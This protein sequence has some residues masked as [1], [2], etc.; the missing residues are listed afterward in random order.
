LFEARLLLESELSHLAAKRRT[1]E[2][3]AILHGILKQSEIALDVREEFAKLHFEFHRE[4]ARIA[5]NALLLKMHAVIA[6]Q[7]SEFI[8]PAMRRTHR[9]EASETHWR[10]YDSIKEGRPAQAG[11]IARDH[12]VACKKNYDAFLEEQDGKTAHSGSMPT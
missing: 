4:I 11:K 5:G 1:E 10:I 7:S 6:E 12:L 3:L 8:L 9:E 2:D